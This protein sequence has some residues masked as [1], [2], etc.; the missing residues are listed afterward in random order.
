MAA[1]THRDLQLQ[2]A[3]QPDGIDDVADATAARYQRRPPVDQPVMDPSCLIVVWI[4]GQQ[5]LP[6]EGFGE[7][8]DRIGKRLRCNHDC[9]RPFP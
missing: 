7:F 2:V 9:P 5:E 8:G 4:D 3:R 1:A 6:R